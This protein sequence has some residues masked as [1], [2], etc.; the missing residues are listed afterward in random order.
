M[1]KI[2]LIIAVL[3]VAACAFCIA[4]ATST[5]Y[6]SSGRYYNPYTGIVVLDLVTTD[7][8][9]TTF[10]VTDPPYGYIDRIVITHDGNDPAYEVSITDASSYDIFDVDDVNAVNDPCS[11]A[12]SMSDYGSTEFAGV[13]YYGGLTITVA[14]ANQARAF[15]AGDGNDVTVRL[16]LREQWRR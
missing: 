16:Y 6:P 2:I 3:L 10:T 7:I 15:V 1:Q 13:P 11:Y 8:N 9:D 5:S 12:V 14:D 4:T